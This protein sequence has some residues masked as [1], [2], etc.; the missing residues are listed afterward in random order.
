LDYFI[1]IFEYTGVSSKI[2]EKLIT[3]AVI[4]IILFFL[5]YIA[6]KVV[7]KRIKEVKKAYIWRR[8]TLYIYIFLIIILLGRIW[9]KGIDSLAT[10]LGLTSAGLAIAMKDTVTDV[11]GWLFIMWNKPFV[12]G[13][14]IQLKDITGD[15]IRI[16]FFKF[17]VVEVGEWVD[18][19]QSTG[20]IVHIPNNLAIRETLTNYHTG[21]NYIWNEIPMLITFE[22][23]WKKAKK[24]LLKIALARAEHLTKDAERQVIKAARQY[25]IF[26]NI[27]TPTVYTSIQESGV[28]LTMRYIV[29]PRMRRI[30]EHQICED[31]IS[32]FAKHSDIDF[33][34]PTTR[35]YHKK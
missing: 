28:C 7:K 17:S 24:I 34:Y 18:G 19:E 2:L 33:A 6:C 25:M 21:F 27:L 10:F 3:S 35:F 11:M 14:R 4:F 20:R 1:N 26:F 16:G 9:I 8:S 5:K 12:L 13:D 29:K 31:I 23:G 32:E 15:V 22:S 30:T